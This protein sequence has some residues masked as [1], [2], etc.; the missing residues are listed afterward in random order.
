MT[1]KH[2]IKIDKENK[3]LTLMVS[4]PRKKI[5]KEED[6]TFR[7]VDA[8]KL[9]KNTVVEGYEV[10]YKNFGHIVDNWR[11]CNHEGVYVYPLLEKKTSKP[12]VTSKTSTKKTKSNVGKADSTKPKE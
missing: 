4:V 8:W 9:V 7:G 5:A 3:V 11:I 6:V 10:E 1:I 2:E 12:K